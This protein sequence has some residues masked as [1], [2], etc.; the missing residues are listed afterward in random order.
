MDFLI[1]SILHFQERI[2]LFLDTED[3]SLTQK[4]ENIFFVFTREEAAAT[5][6]REVSTAPSIFLDIIMNGGSLSWIRV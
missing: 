2:R 4:P 3:T 1:P 5:Q 6:D